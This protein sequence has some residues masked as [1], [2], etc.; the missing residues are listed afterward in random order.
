MDLW[1]I[2]IGARRSLLSTFEELDDGD[3]EMPSLC[4]EWTIRQVLAHLVLAARPPARRYIAAVTRARGD[5]D[6]AN[7][8]LAVLD[9][10]RPTGELL[11]AYRGVVDY[12][13]SPLAGR[14]RHRSVTSSCTAS[15]CASRSSATPTYRRTTTSR[16]WDSSSAAPVV[17]SPA[18]AGLPCVGSRRTT[19]GH[20]A[21]AKKYAA[22]WPTL[23]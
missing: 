18:R 19:R 16:Y 1:P 3:W 12:R 4:G 2:T 20:G 14:E 17:P 8:A 21:P 22:E 15:T 10:S 7:H 23:R 11:H 6:R 9:A 13:F 5:F